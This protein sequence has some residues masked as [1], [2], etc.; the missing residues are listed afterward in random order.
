MSNI[1]AGPFLTLR[2]PL[3]PS[4][5]ENIFRETLK[6]P[7]I[8]FIRTVDTETMTIKKSSDIREGGL[9]IDSHPLF[10]RNVIV[11]D[12]IFNGE[13]IKE[14][15]IKAR[16]GTNLWMGVTFKNIRKNILF[17]SI[18]FGIII[19]ILFIITMLIIFLVFRSFI[20]NSLISLIS[21]FNK[22]KNKDYKVRL[23]ESS[24]I[25][26]QEV[27]QS[28][29]KMTK[30]LEEFHIALEKA[31]A[32]LEAKVEERTEKLQEKVEELEKFQKLAVGRELKMIELKEK[33]KEIEKKLQGR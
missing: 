14:F 26:I 8:I 27:F 19:L 28:F 31:K 25:E 3:Y 29:N 12:G 6:I 30:N 1:I 7:G 18:I 4:T 22:L 20:I 11:R 15:S 23:G 17:T 24:V 2:K 21:A 5:I 10:E 13:S 9:K 33:I 16:D 32:N